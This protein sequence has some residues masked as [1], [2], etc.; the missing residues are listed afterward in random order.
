M[1]T[2][3]LDGRRAGEGELQERGGKRFLA[4]LRGDVSPVTDAA[5]VGCGSGVGTVGAYQA[6]T[7]QGRGG[8]SFASPLLS[9]R[10]ATQNREVLKAN[11]AGRALKNN[12]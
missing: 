10:A 2:E 1:Q 12:S 7:Q 3:Y 11:M 9:G 6:H 8:D 5:R 4:R